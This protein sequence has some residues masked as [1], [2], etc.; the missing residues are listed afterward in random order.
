MAL[1]NIFNHDPS[2]ESCN[3]K[4]TCSASCVWHSERPV[5]AFSG[6]RSAL[7]YFSSHALSNIATNPD[8]GG[9]KKA[10]YKSRLE[11]LGYSVFIREEAQINVSLGNFLPSFKSFVMLCEAFN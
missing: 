10:F 6:W 11:L 7:F 4:K 3:L 2:T 1:V 5:P 8:L 9:V